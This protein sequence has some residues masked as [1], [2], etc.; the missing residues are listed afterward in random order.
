MLQYLYLDNNQLESVP[1]E[2]A[3]LE[4]LQVLHL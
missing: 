2:I 3:E 4:S 1:A